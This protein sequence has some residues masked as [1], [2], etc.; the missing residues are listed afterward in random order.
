MEH[1]GQWFTEGL[2]A[3]SWLHTVGDRYH[4][5]IGTHSFHI[6]GELHL[7]LRPPTSVIEE[8]IY[9]PT[10]PTCPPEVSIALGRRAG[11]SFNKIFDDLDSSNYSLEL[12][13][14]Q[15][16]H[17]DF[18]YMSMKALDSQNEWNG[19]AA[20]VWSFGVCFLTAYLDYLSWEGIQNTVFYKNDHIRFMSLIEAMTRGNPAK[21]PTAESAFQ[22]W[23]P[24]LDEDC[25]SCVSGGDDPS[26]S[27]QE[28]N[29]DLPA[30]GVS[31]SSE[32][33]LLLTLPP[34]TPVVAAQRRLVLKRSGD[35]VE[36]NKTRRNRNN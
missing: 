22:T 7:L 3:L 15:F 9:D 25:D 30:V 11:F 24:Q 10:D 35:P 5:D 23:L 8:P 33:S 26:S 19:R 1:W 34:Q 27:S 2:E 20:D 18:E 16:S 14:N 29:S 13:Q 21:R 6:N 28:A 36:R 32:T 12:L 17:G 31:A 4:G